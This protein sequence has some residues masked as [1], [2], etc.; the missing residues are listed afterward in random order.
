VQNPFDSELQNLAERSSAGPP[1][2][3]SK[4]TDP[5]VIDQN[6]RILGRPGNWSG[7]SE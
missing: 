1:E 6:L 7:R 5:Q 4:I 2:P 3:K